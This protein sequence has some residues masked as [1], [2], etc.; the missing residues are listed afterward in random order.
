MRFWIKINKNSFNFSKILAHLNNNRRSIKWCV[1]FGKSATL[2]WTKWRATKF[3]LQLIDFLSSNSSLVEYICSH[4][5]R[6]CSYTR[7]SVYSEYFSVFSILSA[8]KEVFKLI[9]LSA[10]H[11]NKFASRTNTEILRRNVSP[12]SVC[13][14]CINFSHKKARVSSGFLAVYSR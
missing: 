4:N 13:W 3:A 8:I 1:E 5:H 9:W 12:Q 2:C 6:W 7:F 11:L 14:Y 10:Y